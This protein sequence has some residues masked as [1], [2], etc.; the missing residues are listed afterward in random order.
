[1]C[2]WFACA[3]NYWN[4][5]YNDQSHLSSV[6]Q[7]GERE[8]PITAHL[9]QRKVKARQIVP[10]GE[11]IPEGWVWQVTILVIHALE[12]PVTDTASDRRER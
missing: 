6:F 2:R 9:S 8:A 12:V 5:S 3:Q 4:R 1:M 11:Q 7:E 10:G